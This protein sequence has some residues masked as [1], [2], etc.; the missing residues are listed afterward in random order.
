MKYFFVVLLMAAIVPTAIAADISEHY[1]RFEISDRVEL[2]KLTRVISI[3]NVVGDTVYAYA[4][5]Y[6]LASFIKLGYE[7]TT[8]PRPSTLI[9]PDMGSSIRALADWDVYPTYDAYVSMMYQFATDFDDVSVRH[10][11]PVAVP[12][13]QYRVQRAG[14][15][16]PVRQDIR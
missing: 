13:A 14:P 4:N 6:E 3:D 5:D 7:Y 10:G 12:G 16:A 15:S 8:L 11:L 2:E 9:T 1:F